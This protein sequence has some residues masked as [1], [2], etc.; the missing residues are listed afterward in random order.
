MSNLNRKAGFGIL[1]LALAMALVLFGGAG[2]VAYCQAWAYLGVFFAAEI[3]LTLYLMKADPT[4]LERR[5]LLFVG[6]PLALG[7]YWALVRRRLLP[8]V[9]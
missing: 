1:T 7:S 9:F 8:G 3:L 2:T 5:M 4:L 6:T